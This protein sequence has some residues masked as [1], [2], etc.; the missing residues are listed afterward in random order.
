M[1]R[2]ESFPAILVSALTVHLAWASLDVMV[3]D[4]EQIQVFI[5]GAEKD[6]HDLRVT[7]EENRLTVEQ[8][9]Y[10]INLKSLGAE[11]WMQIMIRLPLSWKGS[12]DLDTISAP[13]NVRGLSGTDFTL[14]TVS[15]DISAS[16]LRSMTAALR[17]LSGSIRA[18]NIS[19][20]KLNLR[21]ISGDI[22]VRSCGYDVYRVNTVSGQTDLDM[23]QPFERLD[24]VSVSGNVRVFAPVEYVDASLRSVSGRLLTRDVSIQHGAPE[25]KASSVSGNFEINCSTAATYEEE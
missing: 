21:S 25:A 23:T 14:D 15:G 11:H 22:T 3:E 24:C 20:E 7:C 17:S 9:S 1:N 19:G 10:G 8:P 5:S 13:L 6:V 16:D 4:V 2:N 12:V 18:E